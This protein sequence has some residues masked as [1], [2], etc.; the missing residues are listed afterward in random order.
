VSTHLPEDPDFRLK[1][2]SLARGHYQTVLADGKT[3]PLIP[4]HRITTETFGVYFRLA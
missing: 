1:R 4:L 2:C 3:V